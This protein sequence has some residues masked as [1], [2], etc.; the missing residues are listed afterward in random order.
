MPCQSTLPYGTSRNV[1][2]LSQKLG[3]SLHAG[4]KDSIKAVS[5]QNRTVSTGNLSSA[6]KMIQGGHRQAR[7]KTWGHESEEESRCFLFLFGTC[8]RECEY[9]LHDSALEVHSRKSLCSDSR[10]HVLSADLIASLSVSASLGR[11]FHLNFHGRVSQARQ[12]KDR[13]EYRR[14]LLVQKTEN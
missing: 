4:A 5:M 9:N 11:R 6:K 14:E 3:C 1:Q 2:V 8:F 13:A 10:R 12:N 7:G